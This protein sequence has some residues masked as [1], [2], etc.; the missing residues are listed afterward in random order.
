M[1]RNIFSVMLVLLA[2]TSGLH[3]FN[4]CMKS[5]PQG[6]CPDSNKWK[7]TTVR[8]IQDHENDLDTDY[9]FVALVGKVTKQHDGDTYFFTDAT[10]TIE[11]DSDIKLPVGENIVVRGEI[12]Q[13][14]LHIGPLELNVESWRHV[15]KKGEYL[16]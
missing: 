1:N 12:D 9:K 8:W 10:G 14:F 4:C 6:E 7:V 15:S 11:L 5:C 2:M 16:K 3:A 13:A